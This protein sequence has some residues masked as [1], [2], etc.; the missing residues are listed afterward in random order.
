M[1]QEVLTLLYIF[2]ARIVDVSMGTFR[3]ILISQ[4]HRKITPILGFFE[5]LIWL[6]AIGKALGNLHGI[7]SYLIYAGGFATG[8]YVGMLLESKISIGFQSIRIITSEKVTA[9]PMILKDEGFD[10]SILNGKGSKGDIFIIYTVVRKRNVKRIVDI[11]NTLEPNAY[12]T[13]ENVNSHK[14]GFVNS[15]RLFPFFGRNV[16]KKE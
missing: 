13:I 7:Y 6:T 4:G 1:E 3:I 8:N 10:I 16:A 15:K 9:L 11:V 5:I 12:I 2:C 14:S